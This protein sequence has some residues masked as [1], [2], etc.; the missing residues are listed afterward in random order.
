MVVR[1]VINVI[2]VVMIIR[3]IS[4]DVDVFSLKIPISTLET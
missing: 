1:V 2:M 4:I 3:V